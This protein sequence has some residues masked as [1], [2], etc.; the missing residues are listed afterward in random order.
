L[1]VNQLIT[2]KEGIGRVSNRGWDRNND[3]WNFKNLR[4][5]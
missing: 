2:L 3:D 4:G 1:P 5:T